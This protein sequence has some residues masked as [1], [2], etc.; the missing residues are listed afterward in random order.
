MSK[1]DFATGRQLHTI[2]I[3]CM[4][5]GIPE[6]LEEH[7][8]TIGEAGKLIRRLTSEKAKVRKN[9]NSTKGR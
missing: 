9:S 5:H 4:A 6:P 1:S 3:L 8:M 2:A 7:P